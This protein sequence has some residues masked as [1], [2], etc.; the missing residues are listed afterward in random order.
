MSAVVLRGPRLLLDEGIVSGRAVLIEHGRIAALPPA[1][2]RLAFPSVALPAEALIAPGFIDIQVNGGGGVQFN[3]APSAEAVQVIAAAHRRLGTT[4]LLPTLITDTAETMCAAAAA[5]ETMCAIPGSGVLGLHFEGPFLN[6]ERAGIHRRE[7][8]RVPEAED[9][10]LL[11]GV[12][13]RLAG[14]PLML[15]LAPERFDDTTLARLAASGIVLSA[16]HSAAPF[17][18]IV[19]ALRH[20]LRGFTHLY[21]A[22]PPLAGREPGTVGAA[23][24]DPDAWCG[25][26]ADGL[27][28]HPAMLRLA[29]RAKGERLVLVSDAMAP[30]G[31]TATEFTLAGR[32]ITRSAGALRAAD[33]TLAGADLDMAQA[34]R[35]AVRL[36]G[37]PTAAAL[38]MASRSPAEW[39]GLADRLGHI[40]PG[41]QADLV[42]L[43]PELEVLETWCEGMAT[44]T[45]AR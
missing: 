6:P 8:I 34:V 27:H 25:I 32:V 40:A 21:N 20:G 37:I 38:R 45:L 29:W 31:T 28:V 2:E 43:S 35:N 7:L 39:L 30:A 12:S 1:S 36:L 41:Y 44:G 18:R 22:M 13:D 33:G 3:D 9:L 24:L 5:V 42:L 26:I 11:L 16:G 14:A 4:G 23:L 19:S 17:E 15:T 10:R